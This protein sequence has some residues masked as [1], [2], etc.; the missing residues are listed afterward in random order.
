MTLKNTTIANFNKTA[1]I[2]R[3]KINLIVDG[4]T[5]TGFGEQAI[6]GQNGIQYAGN[7][8]IQDTRISGLIYNADNEWKNCSTAIYNVSEGTTTHTVLN[9]VICENVDSSYYATGGTTS[10]SGGSFEH[11]GEDNVAVY[12]EEEAT[13]V[14]TGGEF[15]LRCV[16]VPGPRFCD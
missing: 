13:I 12:G 16:P 11:V 8:T 7:A 5:I 15:D 3:D 9:N 14:I 4:C 10:I 2:A 6:I 1:V